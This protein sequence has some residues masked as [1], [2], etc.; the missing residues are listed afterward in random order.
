MFCYVYPDILAHNYQPNP[1]GNTFNGNPPVAAGSQML[2]QLETLNLNNIGLP[3]LG[4]A[5]KV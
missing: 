2:N 4:A 3:Q 5:I 1:M